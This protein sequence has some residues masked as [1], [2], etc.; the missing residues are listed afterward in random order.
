M[1][2]A[3]V[4]VRKRVIALVAKYRRLLGL[5]EWRFDVTFGSL[6]DRPV[7]SD[8]TAVATVIT[9]SRYRTAHI[10]VDL[11]TYIRRNTLHHLEADIIHELLHCYSARQRAL[12]DYLWAWIVEECEEGAA[13]DMERMVR[14]IRGL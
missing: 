14:S 5:D 8:E 12:I 13:V 6:A 7:G 1:A 10:Q 9:D 11:D 4:R 2:K 3:T